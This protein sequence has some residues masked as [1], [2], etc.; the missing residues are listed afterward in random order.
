MTIQTFWY[1]WNHLYFHTEFTRPLLLIQMLYITQK[2]QDISLTS[3]MKNVIIENSSVSITICE[4]RSVQYAF[5]QYMYQVLSHSLIHY[6]DLQKAELMFFNTFQY[7][8]LS[9]ISL[10]ILGT[11]TLIP[12][13]RL[14]HQCHQQKFLFIHCAAA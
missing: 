14:I 13:Y 3:V 4:A 9:C 2:S 1:F 5:P 11:V 6:S 10:Y 12:V 8:P 7:V